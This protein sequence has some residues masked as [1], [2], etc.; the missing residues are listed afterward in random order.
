MAGR[1]S[2]EKHQGRPAVAT[3]PM[4]DLDRVSYN[5]ILGLADRL[6]KMLHDELVQIIDAHG[7]AK[8][9]IDLIVRQYGLPNSIVSDRN[10]VSTSI[11][12]S[13][14][15]RFRNLMTACRKNLSTGLTCQISFRRIFGVTCMDLAIIM[16]NKRVGSTTYTLGLIEVMANLSPPDL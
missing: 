5:P 8:V 7:L 4:I 12:W 10:S 6:K 2:R 3:E 14:Q 9:L 1:M 11:S 15:D 16:S 13:L